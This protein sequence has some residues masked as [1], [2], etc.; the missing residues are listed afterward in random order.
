MKKIDLKNLYPKYAPGEP[1]PFWKYYADRIRTQLRDQFIIRQVLLEME[2]RVRDVTHA[3][4]K[5]PTI[6]GVEE[7][8]QCK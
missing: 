2:G 3:M 4:V 7:A 8:P 6:E 1:D 5:Q